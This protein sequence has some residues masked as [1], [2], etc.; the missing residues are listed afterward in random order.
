MLGNSGLVAFLATAKP[1]ESLSF[2]KESLGLTVIDDSPFAL[3]LNA[4][5]T[6]IRIQKV[7]SVISVPYTVLGW[8]VTDINATVHELTAM[9]VQCERYE[10]LPQ[11]VSGIWETPGGA[12]VIWFKD[13]DGNLLSITQDA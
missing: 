2:Y 1:V 9:G 10:D 6:T 5:G 8:A 11:D 12:K 7:E 4:N 3:V 13:P